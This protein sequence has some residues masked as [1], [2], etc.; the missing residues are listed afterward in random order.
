[1]DGHYARDCRSKGG[2]RGRS[3]GGAK[4]DDSVTRVPH[5]AFATN[6]AVSEGWLLDSGCTHHMSFSKSDFHILSGHAGGGVMAAGGDALAIEGKGEVWV[7]L[8]AKS[9]A[10]KR[11]DRL[12]L[13]NVLYVPALKQRLLSISQLQNDG[14]SALF[15]GNKHYNCC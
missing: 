5:F 11:V 12:V 9:R 10:G 8:G 13:R 1:M 14:I 6:L 4:S 7:E 2:D 3:P 15:F